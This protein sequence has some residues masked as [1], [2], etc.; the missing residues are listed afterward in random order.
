MELVFNGV[1][2]GMLFGIIAFFVLH[3]VFGWINALYHKIKDGCLCSYD[4]TVDNVAVIGAILV[5]LFWVGS[6]IWLQCSDK[7]V[8]FYDNDGNVIETY[9]ITNYDESFFNSSIEFTLKDG[10]TIVKQD[11]IY[12]IR[13]CEEDN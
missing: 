4:E 11:C 2:A 10:R 13:F 1:C 8:D 9:Q 5:C 12:D 7:W 3:L 6:G